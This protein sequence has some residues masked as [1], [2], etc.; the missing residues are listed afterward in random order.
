MTQNQTLNDKETLRVEN[1]SI[2]LKKTGLAVVDNVSF[3]IKKGETVA[4]LGESGAGKTTLFRAVMGLL[5]SYDW[6]TTGSIHIAGIKTN[7]LLPKQMEPIR[8]HFM[9]CIFQEPAL[10][11]NP[12]IK[13]DHQLKEAVRVVNPDISPEDLNQRILE[14]VANA[15]LTPEVVVGRYPREL[16]GGQR[17]RV[18]IALSLVCPSPLLLADEPSNSLDS[19]T[20]TELIKTI[21]KLQSTG[22][23]QTFFIITHDLSVLQAL[24]CERVLFMDEGKLYEAG[25][26]QNVLQNPVHEKLARIVALKSIINIKNDDVPER[27]NLGAPLVKVS[28]FNF[29][30]LQKSFFQKKRNSIVKDVNFEIQKGE[31]IALVGNS[32]CG[33]S[34][35]A[36]NITKE[37]NGFEGEILFD[38]KPINAF[39]TRKESTE[40]FRSLQIIFQEPADTFDPSLTMRQNL[41]ECFSSMGMTVGEIEEAFNELLDRLNLEE[42]MLDKLPKKLSGGQKQRFALLRAFGSKP[43]MMI[44]DEPFNNLDMIAQESL[45]SLLKERKDDPANP[46]SCLLISH[47]I[48][49]V[50]KLCDQVLV[51][52]DGKIAEMGTIDQILYH[53]THKAT[54]RLIEAAKMLGTYSKEKEGV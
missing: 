24:E 41:V 29:G 45:I 39:N 43:A 42:T 40:F 4:L 34:T 14:A 18:G 10:S 35:I 32:G 26:I 9:R 2:L 46:M 15:G 11:L 30:Y 20:V 23:I 8:G 27:R 49:V 17:Q 37:L 12:S 19:V 47:D 53:S 3:S 5:A 28:N 21:K 22:N 13:V 52:D 50:S 51:I 31:F 25:N 33:K 7:G 16:S 1:L 48:G 6:E 44:A 36:S 54:Q 38:S